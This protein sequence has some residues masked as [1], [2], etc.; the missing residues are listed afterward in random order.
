MLGNPVGLWNML[1][2]L[3][4]G[5]VILLLL[6]H[7]RFPMRKTVAIASAGLVI[8]L[9]AET[10]IYRF[11]GLMT[12]IRLYSVLIHLP[13]LLLFMGLSR[14]RNAQM[15]FQLL[16]AI[17]FL[18]LV[19]QSASLCYMFSG[20]KLWVLAAAYAALSVVVVIFLVKYLRPMVL[21]VFSQVSR[22]WWLMCLL[23]AW[24]YAIN[25]YLIPGLAG[26]TVL[27]TLLKSAISLLMAGVY[28]VF[29][30]LLNSLCRETEARYNARLSD[31]RLSALKSRIQV[32]AAAEE[33][34]RVQRHDLRHR[35]RAIAELARQ[36]DSK[37]ILAL[38]GS[39]EQQ[40]DAGARK[41]WCTAPILDAMFSYYF[42]EAM[43]SGIQVEARISIPDPLPVEE[44]QLA[45]LFANALENAIRANA[46]LPADK[47]RIICR[48]VSRPKLMLEISNP[49]AGAVLFDGQGLPISVEAGHGLGT[50]SIKNMCE[51]YGYLCRFEWEDGWFRFLVV[52]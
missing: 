26:E 35:L 19:H 3:I 25:I 34:A 31:A 52:Q 24:Y 44:E 4:L 1:F 7:S 21:Q 13:L 12:L 18:F 45:I 9:S 40:L 38:V 6:T 29:L 42:T 43:G 16:S 49:T 37:A 36:D 17:L 47:R 14:R 30:H 15:L 11:W 5:W 8:M 10:L 48:A 23:M 32:T 27:A 51:K 41:Q 50:R 33:S 20:G 46:A 2:F 28:A 22:G 39:A